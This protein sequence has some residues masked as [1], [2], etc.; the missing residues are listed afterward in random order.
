MTVKVCIVYDMCVFSNVCQ[1]LHAH[2]W[3][4]SRNPH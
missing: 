3:S 4:D 2:E 1:G